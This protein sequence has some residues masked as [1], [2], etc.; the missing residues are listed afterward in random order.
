MTYP[1]IQVAGVRSFGESNHIEST[2]VGYIGF[3]LV[4]DFHPEDMTADEVR[5]LIASLSNNI[6]PVLITYL[7]TPEMIK[8]LAEYI[9]ADGVQLHSQPSLRE[10]IELRRIAPHLS[11]IKSLVVEDDNFEDLALEVEKFSPYADAFITDTFDPETGARGAT[12][13]THDWSVSR[14][15]TELS[16][17]PVIIAGGLTSENVHTAIREIKP[18]GVDVHTGVEDS[19]GIKDPM[20]LKQFTANAIEAF[21]LNSKEYINSSGLSGDT[22]AR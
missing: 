15:I 4:L 18:F 17:K 2:G 16:P 11:I 7:R 22:S 12:G 19:R 9:G 14:R 1:Y 21:Q 8:E 3:P 20:L 13:R 5:I 10:L 6:H